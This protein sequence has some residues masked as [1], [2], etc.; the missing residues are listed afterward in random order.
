MVKCS[1]K[2]YK[3]GKLLFSVIYHK[4]H[5]NKL[6]CFLIIAFFWPWCVPLKKSISGQVKAMVMKFLS[7]TQT[8]ILQ[9]HALAC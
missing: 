7:I 8:N 4:L 5:L 9:L 6:N 3:N 2:R 1:V